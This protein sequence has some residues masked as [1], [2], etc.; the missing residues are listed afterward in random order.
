MEIKYGWVLIQFHPYKLFQLI[1]LF[2][3]RY[4]FYEYVAFANPSARI[5]KLRGGNNARSRRVK[6]LIK[7][8]MVAI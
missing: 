1:I 2:E 5:P 3:T 8:L 6:A 7:S 4:E